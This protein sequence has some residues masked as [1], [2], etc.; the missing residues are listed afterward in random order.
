MAFSFDFS[1]VRIEES[2]VE[3]LDTIEKNTLKI[4]TLSNL[5]VIYYAKTK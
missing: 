3:G 5:R 2:S 4:K 1:L